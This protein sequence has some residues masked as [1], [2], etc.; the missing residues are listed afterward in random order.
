MSYQTED[1][2][3]CQ[4]AQGQLRD[5]YMEPT[6]PGADENMPFMEHMNSQI[7]RFPIQT[8]LSPGNGKQN[9]VIVTY[10]PRL[11]EDLVDE[12]T[13]GVTNCVSTT[14]YGNI[15][16]T[17][18]PPAVTQCSNE[19]ISAQ[20]LI[21]YCGDNSSYF[22]MR[23]SYHI[24]VVRRKLATQLAEEAVLLYGTWGRDGDLFPVG[25]AVG[26]VNTSDEYIWRTRV[27]GSGLTP[28]PFDPGAWPT[29]RMAY[30]DLGMGEV[31]S[32]GGKTGREYMNNSMIGCCTDQG[33]DL[34]AAL[35][36]FGVSYAYD[37][38]IADALGDQDKFLSLSP[39]ALVPV[40]FTFSSWKD[41]V[42]QTFLNTGN[43]QMFSV[44]D[45][46]TNI[47][48]DV[49]LTWDCGNLSIFVCAAAKLINLPTDFYSTPDIYSGKNGV[50]KVLIDNP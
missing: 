35:R 47:P 5:L 42:S 36:T 29:L 2:I 46:Q 13:V 43:T 33:T 11:T 7:N 8:T 40:Y 18:T 12:G 50:V 22:A 39:G 10:F 21:R 24:D 20:D 26:D 15:S 23:L 37:R 16:R 14:K 30:D 49:T 1:L 38:R 27:A 32:F 45:P 6:W 17:Y 31:L 34:A 44:A 28:A 41:G 4:A 48:M 3:P 9:D 25:N 19:L